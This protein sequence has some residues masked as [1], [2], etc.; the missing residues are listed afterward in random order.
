MKREGTATRRSGPRRPAKVSGFSQ[1]RKV[2]SPNS[3]RKRPRTRA[4]CAF[5]WLSVPS[6]AIDHPLIQNTMLRALDGARS[7][8]DPGQGCEFPAAALGAMAAAVLVAFETFRDVVATRVT[9]R[10]Q[11]L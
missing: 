3:A 2:A 11:R 9:R 5:N 1:L 7:I 6:S 8:L 10:G 4:H